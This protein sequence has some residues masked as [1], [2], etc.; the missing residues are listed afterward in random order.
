VSD[1]CLI[2]GATGFIGGRLARRLLLEGYTVRCL[3]R[4]SSDTAQLEQLDVQLAIGDLTRADS[5]VSAVEGCQYVVHCGALVSDWA[6][7]QEIASIN[8]GGTRNLLEAAIAAAVKRFVHLSSTDVY[9]YPNQAQ[10]D[11]TYTATSFRNWY[12]QTKL[13]AEAEVR[14]A[15]A[16]HTLTSVILRPATVYGPGSLDVVGEIARAIKAHHM[17]LIDRGRPIA[18]LCYVENLLDAAVLALQHDAAP[19]EAFNVS[20]GLP[21]TW[22]QFTDGLADGLDCPGVR[23]SLPYWLASSIGF[24]LEHG[25]RL[26]RR[27]TG[28]SLPPLLS[29]Q[30]VQVLGRSQDFSNR[31]LCQTLGWEPRVDYQS[32]LAAT[33]EWLKHE[34]LSA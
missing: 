26:L 12:A 1:T 8:V 20:D 11:E 5:L 10:T 22:R 27:A 15:Q 23:F 25:Y 28:L 7:A 21:I 9:G 31:K 32:G 29:R 2:T 18:G 24:T 14:R 17:L 4:P 19:G 6:T 30:A 34:H 3:V 33:V 16:E 13:Q